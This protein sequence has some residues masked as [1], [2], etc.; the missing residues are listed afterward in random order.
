LKRSG[1]NRWARVGIVIVS[2]L[3]CALFLTLLLFTSSLAL[4]VP[5]IGA[6]VFFL[7]LTIAPMYAVPMDMSRDYAGMGSA[8]IIMGVGLAGIVSPIAFGWLVDASGSWNLPF[9]VGVGILL[10]GAALASRLRPDRPFQP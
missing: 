7:E 6:A 1:S 4:A 5:L 9:G 3:G 10:S 2:L 8:Y